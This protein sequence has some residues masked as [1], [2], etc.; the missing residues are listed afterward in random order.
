MLVI[1]FLITCKRSVYSF[2][3]ANWNEVPRGGVNSVEHCA[4]FFFV[5]IITNWLQSSRL[6]TEC[7]WLRWSKSARNL[8]CLVLPKWNE[9]TSISTFAVINCYTYSTSFKQVCTRSKSCWH[10]FT[11]PVVN[12]PTSRRFCECS[13]STVIS[14]SATAPT[15]NVLRNRR[16]KNKARRFEF[17]TWKMKRKGTHDVSVFSIVC[18]YIK[19]ANVPMAAKRQK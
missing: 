8:S 16:G 18:V 12:G 11:R 2:T 15:G 9:R 19:S 1:C 6:S 17:R 4:I 10:N 13:L 14:A 7:S 5:R 3:S